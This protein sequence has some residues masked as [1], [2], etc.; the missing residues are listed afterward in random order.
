MKNILFFLITTL[1]T[2]NS[3]CQNPI[4]RTK[5]TADPSAHVFNN[6]LYIYTSHDRDNATYFDMENWTVFSTTNMVDWKD[7]G[8]VFSLNDIKWANKWAWAPDAIERNG[9]YYLYYP[10]ERKKIGVAVGN[11]PIGPFKDALGKPLVDGIAEPFAGAE[12]I[13]P[14]ILLDDD[15]QAY[16]YFGC[17]EARVVK[18]KPN[19]VERDGP[20]H[21]VLILDKQGKRLLW[22]VKN[23]KEPALQKYNGGD[24]VYGEGPWMFKRNNLYYYVY[25]NGWA[26]DATMVYA[27]SQNPM[28]PFVYQGK[29]MESV[30]SGTS[31]GSIV[32]YKGQW[33]VFYHTKDLS[34]N[35]FKRSVCVDQ[36]FFNDKGEIIP[37]KPTKKG[38]SKID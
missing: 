36:L 18:L 30:S 21:E 35:G 29:V 7:H 19:M 33:Y 9:K 8:V 5:F 3:Y 11:T 38:V 37:V 31:H 27:T 1:T 2:L 26:K 24:G 28:G 25:S 20:L 13:D 10:V 23:K 15:G 17:R 12:P 16:M 6:R 14:A 34:G 22:K 32:K 4:I